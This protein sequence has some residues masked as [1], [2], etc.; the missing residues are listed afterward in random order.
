MCIYIDD[1]Q[2]E[3][4]IFSVGDLKLVGVFEEGRVE[5]SVSCVYFFSCFYIQQGDITFFNNFLDQ[6]FEFYSNVFIGFYK[7]DRVDINTFCVVRFSDDV[8]WYRVV[9]KKQVDVDKVQVMFLDY[10]NV[11]VCVNVD[12]RRLLL[13]FS[14]FFLQVVECFFVGVRVKDGFW[15]LEVIILFLNF[16]KDK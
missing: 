13:R 2:E 4:I 3:F 12:F 5:V 10:G 1:V 15:S 6:M 14:E 7:L 8:I 11:E 9:I 16:I